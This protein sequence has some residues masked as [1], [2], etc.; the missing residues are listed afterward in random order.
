MVFVNFAQSIHV[1]LAYHFIWT[2]YQYL[3]SVVKRTVYLYFYI[4]ILGGF[5][6]VIL[7]VVVIV[8]VL[9]TVIIE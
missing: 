8:V 6:G 3:N 9:F 4:V 2:F 1:S 5:V 7:I